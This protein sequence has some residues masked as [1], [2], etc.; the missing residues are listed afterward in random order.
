M[1]DQAAVAN[2]LRR[3]DSVS[4]NTL[5]STRL[6][7][8]LESLNIKDKATKEAEEFGGNAIKITEISEPTVYNDCY[9]VYALVL[10]T[11]D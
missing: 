1:T 11:N 3:D 2:A 8:M 4:R 9:K 6:D 5:S 10:I 7:Q